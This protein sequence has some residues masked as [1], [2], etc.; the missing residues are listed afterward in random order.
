V[1]GLVRQVR[2]AILHLRGWP[3]LPSAATWAALA[4]RGQRH[5]PCDLVAEP[6]KSR[7]SRGVAAQVGEDAN[8]GWATRT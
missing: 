5:L 8:L 2:P 7:A 1:L 4:A 6:T 3:R